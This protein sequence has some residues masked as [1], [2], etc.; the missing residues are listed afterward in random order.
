MNNASQTPSFP[1]LTNYGTNSLVS[2]S[3]LSNNNSNSIGSFFSKITMVHWLIIFII[4]AILGINIFVYIG[5]GTQTVSQFVT[6]YTNWFLGLFGNTLANSTTQAVNT[7]ATGTKAATD[8]TANTITSGIDVTKQIITDQPGIQGANASSSL[9]NNESTANNNSVINTS[10]QEQ[11]LLN[12]TLNNSV[13]EQ[14]LESY[15]PDNS[16]SSIQ[17]SKSTSKSGWCY[18]GEERGYRSCSKVGENNMCMSGDIFPSQEI[19]VN[20]S[21]RL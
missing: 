19:C 13:P 4:L 5:K 18:I 3:P 12:N 20:P 16:I 7:A 2:S 9:S 10:A 15:N 11:N 14:E 1:S 21:L 6:P 17:N 8:I